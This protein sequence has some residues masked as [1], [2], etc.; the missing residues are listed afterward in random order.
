MKS[1]TMKQARIS[2]LILTVILP[3]IFAPPLSLGVSYPP[4]VYYHKERHD[5]FVK[6][7][8]VYLFHS[9]IDDT[10][11]TIDINDT[12]AVHRVTQSC[13]VLPIGIIRVISFI[14]ENYI[15]GEVFAGEIKPDDIAKK[16]KVSCLVIS[17]GICGQKK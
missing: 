13:E 15:K 7:D 16:G 11:K 1:K 2:M 4:E 6:G 17:A 5:K 8:T 3:T 12:L 9:G 14:G 10:K